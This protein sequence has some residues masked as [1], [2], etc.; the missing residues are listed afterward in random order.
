MTQQSKI[1]SIIIPIY[2]QNESH[3]AMSLSSIN[4]Q[5]DVDFSTFDVHLVNDG[6]DPID[7]EMLRQVFSNLDLYYHQLEKNVGPGLA[8]Q[9][10]VDH[11]EGQYLMFVDSDDWL[12]QA[13]SLQ[14]FFE[15]VKTTGNHEIISSYYNR[16][17]LSADGNNIVVA[18]GLFEDTSV[19]PRWFNRQFL[20]VHDLRFSSELRLFE[21]LY[22]TGLAFK[23]V[24]DHFVIARITYYYHYRV[25]SL[26]HSQQFVAT[27]EAAKQWRLQLEF[28]RDHSYE[29]QL[30]DQFDHLILD[31]YIYHTNFRP[32]GGD[33]QSFLEELHQLL[34][35]FPQVAKTYSPEMQDYVSRGIFDQLLSVIPQDDLKNFLERIL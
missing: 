14:Y 7:L 17:G 26:T 16:E 2:Q 12:F 29:T 18:Q 3:L 8:R 22:F 15:A 32:S 24:V 31:I 11:S 5:L 10:G 4:N 35:E 21:D 19:Y 6:G 33:E 28:L 27:G 30:R 20:L 1:V 9:Y 23:L 34:L 13:N 25:S